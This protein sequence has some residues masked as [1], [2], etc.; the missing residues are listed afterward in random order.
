ML[1]KVDLECDCRLGLVVEAVIML[2]V[3]VV[4][5]WYVVGSEGREG[6]CRGMAIECV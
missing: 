5:A 3:M 2:R 4:F 1:T 6:M